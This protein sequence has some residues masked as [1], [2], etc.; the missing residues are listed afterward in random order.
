MSI[1]CSIK[2]RI[3]FFFAP[4]DRD[5]IPL[6]IFLGAVWII[7]THVLALCYGGCST[8]KEL[9]K[10]IKIMLDAHQL[11]KEETEMRDARSMADPVVIQRLFILKETIEEEYLNRQADQDGTAQSNE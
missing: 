7:D 9:H 1:G 3:I 4:V 10:W 6:P 8:P 11:N 5:R 2:H